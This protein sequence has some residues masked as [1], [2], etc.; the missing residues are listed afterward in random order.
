M[1]N[2]LD[3]LK[4]TVKVKT[5]GWLVMKFLTNFT[6][7]L[8]I[9]RYLW[10]C[11]VPWWHYTLFHIVHAYL[12]SPF[13]RITLIP[14]RLCLNNWIKLLTSEGD[15]T[16]EMFTVIFYWKTKWVSIVQKIY[17][18]FYVMHPYSLPWL[19]TSTLIP[20]K[21][22]KFEISMNHGCFNIKN[23]QI[24]TTYLVILR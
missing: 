14:S 18:L 7:Y 22:L 12:P 16:F 3:I 23:W 19:T 8:V 17:I 15:E 13:W 21:K 24:V 5:Y 10:V 2:N 9:E 6:M 20:S 1:K 11:I 4:N